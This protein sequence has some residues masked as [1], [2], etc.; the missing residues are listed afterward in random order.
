MITRS[1][2]GND[3]KRWRL[4]AIPEN[5]PVFGKNQSRIVIY[6]KVN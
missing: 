2:L 3:F 1:G 5:K 6:R 4:A